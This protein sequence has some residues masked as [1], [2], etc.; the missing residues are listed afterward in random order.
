MD[1]ADPRPSPA[2][3][4][5]FW[6]ITTVVSFLQ[7]WARRHTMN[8]DAVSYVEIAQAA[9]HIGV[10][11]LVNAYW[12]P[13]YPALLAVIFRAFHPPLFW[14]STVIHL[15]SFLLVFVNLACFEVFLRELIR[16]QYSQAPAN[17][18]MPLPP[19][20]LWICGYIL[21]IWSSQFWLRSDLTSPD[22]LVAAVAYLAT[23]IL[24]RIL[25][26]NEAWTTFG[27]LG[28]V[29]G[30]GYLAKTVMFPLAFVF[31][32]SAV[33]LA[34]SFRRAFP[35]ALLASAIF[36]VIC[37]PLVV[38]LSRSKG[39]LTFGDSGTINYAEFVNQVDPRFDHW[40]GQPPGTGIPAHPTRELSPAPPLFEFATP[41]SGSYPP[42]YDP[43]YWYDG[44]QAH[45]SLSQQTRALLHSLNLYLRI[46][47][48]T[49]A[50]Y[51]VLLTLFI[52]LRN[53]GPWGSGIRS[54]WAVWL[55]CYAALG[56]Y[57]LVNVEPRYIAWA[58]LML[59]MMVFSGVR[60]PSSSQRPLIPR[61]ALLVAIAPAVAIAV[62]TGQNLAAIARPRPF[63]AWDVA[64]GLQ[65]MGIPPGSGVGFI[66][67][68]F[69]DYW[70]HLA[71]VH[72]VAEIPDW[73]MARFWDADPET[74]S[75][76][77]SQFAASGAACVVTK[78]VP[79]E[80]A[81]QG[82]KQIDGTAYSLWEIRGRP[83]QTAGRVSA[84]N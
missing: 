45:F 3:R 37:A 75:K 22:V 34:P 20:T 71:G 62:S 35:R 83:R 52:L 77:M 11:G 63:E 16:V 56:M 17:L 19:R 36:L 59:L 68:G 51:F 31:L 9:L 26:G 49:G 7:I 72:I 42:W 54:Y 47:S 1:R 50:L 64:Q 43:S 55:P 13:L 58:A 53:S 73:G 38:A 10:K 32:A 69:D 25:A 6:C 21:F 29:L 82:W 30:L 66:G 8:P 67:I 84:K 14:E 65:R 2:L 18:S 15:L 74:K 70:A 48:Q 33:L 40:Q 78:S 27:T 60:V 24:L 4:L 28:I 57:A 41:I 79:P 61:I 80:A 23:A 12:S 44:V 5:C 46:F 81:A 39:R 76:I